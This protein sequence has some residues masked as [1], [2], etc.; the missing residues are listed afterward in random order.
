[1]NQAPSL[2]SNGRKQE[3]QDVTAKETVPDCASIVENLD[4]LPTLVEVALTLSDLLN[5]PRGQSAEDVT[6]L[7]RRDQS[8]LAHVIRKANWRYYSGDLEIDDLQNAIFLLGFEKVKDVA[9]SVAFHSVL[10]MP[11]TNSF[12]WPKFWKHSL[13]VGMAAEASHAERAFKLG[14]DWVQCGNDFE[15]MI[16]FADQLKQQVIG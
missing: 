15:Y 2:E 6:D 5:D 16:R 1:M 9:L 7:I 14:A 12:N 4:R 13:G 11:R 3:R 10:G 8:I